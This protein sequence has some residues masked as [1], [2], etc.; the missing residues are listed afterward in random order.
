MPYEVFLLF[1]TLAVP[2]APATVNLTQPYGEYSYNKGTLATQPD[3][4]PVC[5]KIRLVLAPLLHRP[6]LN[7]FQGEPDTAFPYTLHLNSFNL[8]PNYLTNL[9]I[10]GQ[11]LQTTTT[12]Q[13]LAYN[14]FAWSICLLHIQVTSATEAL[15]KFH[16][17]DCGSAQIS[18]PL[19]QQ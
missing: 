17:F 3:T 11:L 5:L 16:M 7:S 10:F 15:S 2:A 9:I 18:Q 4:T 13:S 12:S 14:T 8:H 19:V 6:S 1:L